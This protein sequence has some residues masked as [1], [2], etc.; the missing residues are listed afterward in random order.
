MMQEH[1]CTECDWVH[2]DNTD[3]RGEGCPLCGSPII[4][5]DDE[6]KEANDKH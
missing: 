5:T 1:R 2:F 4:T 3:R 6:K